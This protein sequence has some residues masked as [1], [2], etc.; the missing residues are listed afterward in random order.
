MS[1]KSV[2]SG[3]MECC[4]NYKKLFFWSQFVFLFSFQLSC[5]S[6]ACDDFLWYLKWKLKIKIMVQLEC[7]TKLKRFSFL[8]SHSSTKIIRKGKNNLLFHYFF[9][10][11]MNNR[12]ILP[13]TV[14]EDPIFSLTSLTRSVFLSLLEIFIPFSFRTDFKIWTKKDETK[15]YTCCRTCTQVCDMKNW[16]E[17]YI[18]N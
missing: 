3:H 17:N 5:Y 7:K 15:N 4:N 10:L 2:C 6:C 18:G 14:F 12:E 11:Y 16:C 13:A 8:T 1:V 9:K